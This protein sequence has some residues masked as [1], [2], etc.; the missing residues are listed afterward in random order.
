MQFLP[1]GKTMRLHDQDQLVSR[2]EG[3][4]K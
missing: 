1:H 2:A 3:L 4:G